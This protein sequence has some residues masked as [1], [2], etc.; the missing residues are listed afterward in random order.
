MG[1]NYMLP[2]H[3]K[4][5]TFNAALFLHKL[6]S[7]YIVL[8]LH[9]LNFADVHWWLCHLCLVAIACRLRLGFRCNF[10]RLPSSIQILDPLKIFPT[11]IAIIVIKITISQ[12][13]LCTYYY[14]YLYKNMTL[15]QTLNSPL[16]SF[17]IHHQQFSLP[18]LCS[19]WYSL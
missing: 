19:E 13:S 14:Y 16:F 10:H 9:S 8:V 7:V 6:P 11:I 3:T 12:V 5:I 18:Y 17:I 4:P 1:I 15:Q 2:T